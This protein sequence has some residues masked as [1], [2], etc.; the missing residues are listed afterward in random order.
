MAAIAVFWPAF[1]EDDDDFAEWNDAA[2][3]HPAGPGSVTF[4]STALVVRVRIALAADLTADP[5]TWAWEDVTQF[6]RY[7]LGVSLTVGRRDETSTVTPGS[8]TLKFSNSDG[9]F[10]RRNPTGQY[11]GLLSK[12]TPIWVEVDAG[13]GYRTRAEMFVNEWPTTWSDKSAN[14]STVTV[15]CAG[16]LRRLGQGEISKS[17]MRRTI[18]ASNPVVYWPLEDGTESAEGGSGVAA[19]LPMETVGAV[20]F[21]ALGDL[22]GADG[23]PSIASSMLRGFITGVSSTSWHVEFAL[24]ADYSLAAAARLYVNSTSHAVWRMALPTSAG[25]GITVYITTADPGGSVTTG[26]TGTDPTPFTDTWHHYALTAT[27]SGANIVSRFY[28]DGVLSATDTTAG[29]LGAPYEIRLNQNF[30]AEVTSAAHVAAGDGTTA[31]GAAALNGY[32]GELAHQRI[33]RLCSEQDIVYSSGANVSPPMGVQEPGTVLGL[34][35]QAET[36]DHGVLYE[37]RWGLA[38]QSRDERENAP[39]AFTLDFDLGQIAEVPRPTDDDQGV[40]NYVTASRPSGSEATIKNAA[41]IAV[42]GFYDESILVNVQVDSDLSDQAGWLVWLATVDVDR[43]PEL[44]INLAHSPELIDAWTALPYG[45]RLNVLHPLDQLPPDVI[46]AFIEGHAEF[47]N[48]LN[49]R[50]GVHTTPAVPYDVGVLAETSGDANEL[51][52]WLDWDSCSLAVAVGTS[53]VSW[54]ITASPVDTTDS[55]DFPRDVWIEGELVTVT[56]CS[57]ASAPQ[58]WTVVR[59]VNGVAKAHA[60]NAV[61]TLAHPVVPTL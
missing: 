34:L 28:I 13:S 48:S 41:S 56:A 27:Q 37:K 30:V 60:A 38:Y 4:P 7:D 58:I 10:T 12:N 57:G 61:I 14:D 16:I 31:V 23:T 50:A 54:S 42:D 53:D 55:D 49:W 17:A 9:R 39:V 29:T 20:S 51:L 40:R 15:V 22:A 46:D 21:D 26:L 6:V 18:D 11:Y 3:S 25:S 36:V 8:A 32:V 47:F 35:R 19:G 33:Q 1:D 24:R 59:S 45:S 43:W 5:S 2:A 52:G 44:N